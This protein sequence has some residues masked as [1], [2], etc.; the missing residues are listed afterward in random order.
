MA[1]SP[2]LAAVAAN[3]PQVAASTLAAP[4]GPK[5]SS[6][7][8]PPPPAPTA[9]AAPPAAPQP[10]DTTP[11]PPNG[12]ELTQP[13]KQADNTPDAPHGFDLQ[14]PPPPTASDPV[15]DKVFQQ[16]APG[17]LLAKSDSYTGL[18]WLTK[19]KDAMFEAAS[20][21]GQLGLSPETEQSLRDSGWFND[22]AKGEFNWGKAVLEGLLKPAAIA[23][24]AAMR[25]FNATTAGVGE[26]VTG[27]Q[28]EAAAR[29][30]ID[31]NNYLMISS[32]FAADGMPLPRNPEFKGAAI[33]APPPMAGVTSLNVMTGETTVAGKTMAETKGPTGLTVPIEPEATVLD[34][35][36]N[37]NLKYVTADQ[38]TKDVLAQTAQAY[39]EKNGT[40]IPHVDTS[41]QAQR[42]LDTA[43]QQTANGIPDVLA[44]FN[45]GDPVN[46]DLLWSARQLVVQTGTEYLRLAKVAEQTGAEEDVAAATEAYGKLEILQGVRHEISAEAGRTLESHTIPVGE[47]GADVEA[48]VEK[49]TSAGMKP[50]DVHKIAASLDT[51]QQIA[52]FAQDAQKPTWGDG[53]IYYVI[54]NY[55]SGPITHAAY[56]AS[57][58]V[59]SV[60]RAGVET[61]IASLV[62]KIQDLA[63][64]TMSAEDINALHAERTTLSE[65]LAEASSTQGRKLGAA[66]AQKMAKRLDQINNQLGGMTTVMPKEAAARFYG[67][68]QGALDA[69]HATWQALKSGAIGALPSEV[70]NTEMTFGKNPIVALG[71]ELNNPVLSAILQG[72]GHV[73]G[74]PTRVV[75]AIHTFQKF[76]TYSESL[77]ALAYRKAA[78]EGLEGSIADQTTALGSR[79]AQLR[80]NPSPEM[81]QAATDEGKY[82]ALMGEPGK[83]GKRAESLA[84][85]NNY[86][87]AI[88]PFYRVMNNISSQ[89]LL[90]RTPLGVF[91]D[92][93]R[94]DI[95]GKNGNAAQATAI[96]KMATGVGILTGAATLTAQGMLHGAAP[97][98][99]NER[100]YNYL[101]GNPPY[102][103]RIGDTNIPMRFFG[104]PGR[105]VAIGADLHDIAQNAQEEDDMTATISFAAHAIGNDILSESGFRGVA[106]LYQAMGDYQRYGQHYAQNAI[107]SAFMPMSV[108]FGQVTRATDP[109]MRQAQGL[110]EA[111]KAKSPFYSDTL[112]PKIDIFGNPMQR[113]S[114]H[115][116]AQKDPVMQALNQLEIYPAPVVNRLSNI[117]LSE[118]Q[119]ADYQTLA[120]RLF[121]QSL[122]PQASDPRWISLT[123]DAQA[124]IVNQA[125]KASRIQ[126]RAAM[127]LLYP[128]IA[129]EN[130]KQK[131]GLTDEP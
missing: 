5:Q 13:P 20:D 83:F 96:G 24:D 51:P 52:K 41:A 28:P 109:Y 67:M 100:D 56:A 59:Q 102:S 57:F 80:N 21:G 36:G 113:N 104:M 12:F 45:H 108:G 114:D 16:S 68:G 126:A 87:K 63:G 50:E 101:A 70:A 15:S 131:L 44:G 49:L 66:D 127:H 4:P 33:T 38:S 17:G 112:V 89:A 62:G 103:V 122:Y 106:E 88:V 23:G 11:P 18:G 130:A 46:R 6:Q 43:M 119:L 19:E 92:Q 82:A 37:L 75:G 2:S 98:D 76:I 35:S 121:Y 42:F 85:S 79:I 53:L 77:S 47:G 91:S 10:Q 25:A 78:S 120:G 55:L 116:W 69:V 74:V 84:N 8:I 40:T 90:E 72:A 118:K 32:G 86:T 48:A 60:L 7:N 3:I 111:M 14:A 54:N 30:A 39:A 65:R 1:D 115:S 34:A 110:V 29:H 128:E 93:V 26:A 31:F 58:L 124:D 99:K 97:D 61:P 129:I 94:A 117:K 9:E 64:K 71:K 95:L 125:I 81:M 73:V 123:S 105:V 107:T 22:Y 27:E